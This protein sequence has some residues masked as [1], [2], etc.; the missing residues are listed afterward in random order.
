MTPQ[1]AFGVVLRQAR[2][3]RGLSQEKLGFETGFHRAYIT[4]FGRG[5]RNPSLMAVFQMAE[6][7]GVSASNLVHRVEA[8]GVKVPKRQPKE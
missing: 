7:L 4:F 8:R 3:R 2:E 1:Q 5:L 6:V